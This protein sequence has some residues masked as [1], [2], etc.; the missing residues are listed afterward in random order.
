M[1]YGR[2]AKQPLAIHKRLKS[3][4]HTQNNK[5]YF[6]NDKEVSSRGESIYSEFYIF[7][8]IT[9]RNIAECIVMFTCSL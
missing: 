8:G 6:L 9:M 3:Q 5:K 1:T 7:W 2:V 4:E